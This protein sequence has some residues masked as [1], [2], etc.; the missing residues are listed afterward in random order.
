MASAMDNT[1][2]TS[3]PERAKVNPQ[4]I[5]GPG[6]LA[7]L[8]EVIACS[9]ITPGRRTTEFWMVVAVI[10]LVSAAGATGKLPPEFAA[11]CLVINAIAYQILR[12]LLKCSAG[13]GYQLV[14]P[15]PLG[16]LAH[17]SPEAAASPTAPA[18]R[19]GVNICGVDCHKGD[20]NCNGYCT[21]RAPKALPKW[22]PVSLLLAALLLLPGCANMS[23]DTKA[24]WRETGSYVGRKALSLAGQIV[25]D[26]AVSS[27]D[28]DTKLDYVQGLSTAFRSRQGELLTANDVRALALAS[29]TASSGLQPSCSACAAPAQ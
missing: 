28:R 15:A 17:G 29:W 20:A 13:N 4:P 1:P 18:G 26:A 3:P 19:W 11:V 14:D 16:A 25:L 9:P 6:E 27:F 21:A 8:A 22:R 12:N 5:P 7:G 2:P 24:K 10:L 23:P